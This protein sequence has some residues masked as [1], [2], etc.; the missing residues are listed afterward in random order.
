[1][2]IVLIEEPA[3][4]EAFLVF[5]IIIP[6][7]MFK[8]V[9]KRYG[10][11]GRLKNRIF[12]QLKIALYQKIGVIYDFSRYFTMFPRFYN[13]VSRSRNIMNKMRSYYTSA[14]K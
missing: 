9:L 7:F 5:L 12:R 14:R 4:F 13:R 11:R 1:V 2:F 3:Y 6:F 8:S 10:F